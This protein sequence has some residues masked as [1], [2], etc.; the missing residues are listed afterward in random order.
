MAYL[1]SLGDADLPLT[2]EALAPEERA[3][4]EG[5]YVFGDRPRDGFVVDVQQNQLGLNRPGGTRRNLLHLGGFAF[6]PPGAPAVRVR[7]EREGAKVIALTLSDPDLVVRAR[8]TR[9][10][11][12]V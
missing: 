1:E 9:K 5:R 11:C 12:G 8:R 3:S 4:L 6:C 2:N 7:F 10:L